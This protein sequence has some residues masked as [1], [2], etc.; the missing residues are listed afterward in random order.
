MDDDFSE[1]L[2]E[3]GS[4]NHPRGVNLVSVADASILLNLSVRTIRYRQAT[5][6]MPRRFKVGRR[7]MYVRSD[8][9]DARATK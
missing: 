6:R 7:Y 3:P 5:G 2:A 1:R 8:I 4:E 9:L